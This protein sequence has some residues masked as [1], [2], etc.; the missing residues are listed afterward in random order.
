MNEE[1][2]NIMKQYKGDTSICSSPNLEYIHKEK[3]LLFSFIMSIKIKGLKPTTNP[4]QSPLPYHS[5]LS[6]NYNVILITNMY[7]TIPS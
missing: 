5:L 1:L 6:P 2:N 3:N 4:L 7:N